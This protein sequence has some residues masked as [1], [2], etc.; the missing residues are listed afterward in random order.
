MSRSLVGLG[1]LLLAAVPAVRAQQVVFEDAAGDAQPTQSSEGPIPGRDVVRLAVESD[2][3]HL[4]LETTLAEPPAG[5]LAGDVVVLYLDTDADPATGEKPVFAEEGGFEKEVAVAV[6]ISYDNGALACAGGAGTTPTGY[7]A[8]AT[9]EDLVT[10]ERGTSIFEVERTPI[11]DTVVR[12]QVSYAELGVR[13]GQKLRVYARES[14]GGFE[15]A[16]MGPAELTLR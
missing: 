7:S 9:V 14:D 4:A 15:D 12:A 10:G 5:T 16:F 1:A 11:E 3:A 8:A 6:C 2:G 13:P